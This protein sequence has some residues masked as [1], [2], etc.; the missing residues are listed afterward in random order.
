TCYPCDSNERQI[1]DILQKSSKYRPHSVAVD[2]EHD[3][4]YWSE[5]NYK[6]VFRSELDGSNE[7][8]IIN[9]S[10]EIGYLTLDVN[11]NWIYYMDNENSTINRC[12]LNGEN[13]TTIISDTGA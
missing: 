8:E 2:S 4:I 6:A 10:A 1:E 9:S 3:N 12:T 11:N 7:I 5:R 13:R